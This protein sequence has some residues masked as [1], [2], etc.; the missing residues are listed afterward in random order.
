MRSTSLWVMSFVLLASCSDRGAADGFVYFVAGVDQ[1]VVDGA[2]DAM[3]PDGTPIDGPPVDA[4]VDSVIGD[5]APGD[6]FFP[7]C[8]AVGGACTPY[9]WEICPV[10]TEPVEPDPHQDCA[11]GGWCCVAAPASTCS[12]AAGANCVFGSACTACWAPATNTALTCESGRVCCEDICD[13]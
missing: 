3:L 6:G 9:R 12:A 8:L 11:G 4:R 10:N 13:S 1:H 5:L 2:V 7:K